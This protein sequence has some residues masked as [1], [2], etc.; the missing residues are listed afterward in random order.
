MKSL[1]LLLVLVGAPALA[2]DAAAAPDC[3]AAVTPVV[4]LGFGSRYAADSQ[5]HSDFDED[6]DAAATA[7]L[8]P[9]DDFIPGLARQ[10]DHLLQADMAATPSLADQKAQ[11]AVANCVIDRINESA[12]AGALADLTTLG[13][14][15]SAPSRVGGIAF[16]SAAV[17]SR[18]PPDARTRAT[19]IWLTARA[20]QIM[21]FLDT[22]APPRASENNLRAWAGLAVTRIGLTL[23]DA[24]LI[25]WGA[26]SASLVACNASHDG[27]LPNAMWRVKLALHDQ[28]HA[29]GPLVVSA[30]LLRDARPG[31]LDD[32]DS[33]IPRI[34]GFTLAALADPEIVKAITGKTQSV[35]GKAKPARDFELAWGAASLSLIPDPKLEALIAPIEQLGNSKLGGDQRLLWPLSSGTVAPSDG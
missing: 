10:T 14:N 6:G 7:A 13:A 26:A 12:T 3:M 23:D 22:A 27:S 4:T 5:S 25:E 20:H 18:V 19:D 1:C 31:L 33:A 29:T 30:A 21:T 34:V 8:K 24:A 17:R 35:G 2:E 11:L 28:L 15:L 9:I 32:C 16:A